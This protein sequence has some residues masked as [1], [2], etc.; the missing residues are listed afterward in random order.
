MLYRISG[1]GEIVLLQEV[2]SHRGNGGGGRQETGDG[3]RETGDRRQETGDGRRETGKS[4]CKE[5]VVPRRLLLDSL[6]LVYKKATRFE[7]LFKYYPNWIL[8][9]GYPEI[10]VRMRKRLHDIDDITARIR[11]FGAN[12]GRMFNPRSYENDR[13]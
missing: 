13:F 6:L 11:I 8:T 10:I 3:R 2:E 9:A 7:A 12:Y 4:N 5:Q 1:R